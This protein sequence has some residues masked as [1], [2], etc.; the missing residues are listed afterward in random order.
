MQLSAANLL[1]ASQ[2]LSRAA[3]PV[4][5]DGQFAAALARENSAAGVNTFVPLEFAEASPPALT[6]APAAPVIV[7]RNAPEPPGTRLDIRV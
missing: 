6:A 3:Q 1:I 4:P 2:Q 5:R 7:V